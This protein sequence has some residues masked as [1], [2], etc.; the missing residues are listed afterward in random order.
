MRKDILILTVLTL[1]H[2]SN[3]PCLTPA[4]PLS[5]SPE[6]QQ[7]T[8]P[9]S[10]SASQPST[11]HADASLPNPGRSRQAQAQENAIQTHVSPA[12]SSSAA[13]CTEAFPSLRSR[14]E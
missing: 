12:S 6:T 5:L 9:L 11:N 3:T 10:Q 4:L 13:I 1:S 2:T 7:A 14:S 8:Q